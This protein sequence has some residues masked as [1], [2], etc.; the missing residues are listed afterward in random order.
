MSSVSI[1]AGTPAYRRLM[2]VLFIGVFMS[3]L[4]T[5]IIAPAIPAL[6][7]AFQIDNRR[8]GLVMIAF[9]LASLCSTAP[10]ASLGDRYGRRPIYLIS[11]SLF[12]LGSLVIALAPTF[13]A[14]VL[15]RVIQGMGGGG[16]IPTASAVI[17]D[18]LP[19]KERGRALGLIGATYGM[20]FVLGPPLAGLVM[21]TLDWHWIFLANL[22]IAAYV[23]FL[24]ARALP[25]QRPAG[26]LP[27]LDWRGIVVLFLLL[28]ALVA[29]V[30]RVLDD[31][32]GQRVWPFTLVALIVL[33]PLFVWVEK[34]AEQPLIPISMFANRQLSLTYFLTLGAGFGMGSVV[35]LT[36]IA[37]LAYA[38]ARQNAG[39]VLLPMVLC[40]II[41]SMGAGRLLN[42]LGARVLIVAGFALPSLGYGACAYTGFGLW[43]F[44]LATMRVGLGVG[45][46]V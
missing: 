46:V 12:A 5:A 11:I 42:R 38:V 3:A 41:G 32:S 39:F 27:A 16:I 8:V 25:S 40:S 31:M 33:L 18:A 10:L 2:T 35:F 4:D 17:A 37:T 23:L 29:S 22:P 45:V 28:S 21:V 15:G 14:V 1:P 13:W 36:S 20:A 19:P 6:R 34:R 7:E 43:V 9:I 24:G 26:V 30:T 44:L